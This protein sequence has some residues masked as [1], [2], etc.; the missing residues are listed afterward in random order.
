[1]TRMNDVPPPGYIPRK[2]QFR[3]RKEKRLTFSDAYRLAAKVAMGYAEA[4]KIE[5]IA[6]IVG[7]TR[8]LIRG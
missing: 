6:S 7:E 2:R 3:S 5:S 1:M 8:K 4:S